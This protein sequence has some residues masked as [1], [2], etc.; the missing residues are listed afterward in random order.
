MRCRLFEPQ[1][2]RPL[3]PDPFRTRDFIPD[4][5]EIVRELRQRSEA[6]RATLKMTEISYGSDR[7]ETLDLFFPKELRTP[8]P[9]HIFTHGGYWRMFSKRDFSYVADTITAAGAIAPLL[10]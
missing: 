1:E 2:E 10:S 9:V 4:F 3:A 7:T 8:A 5:D 6:T